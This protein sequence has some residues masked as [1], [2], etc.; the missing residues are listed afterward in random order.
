MTA[1]AKPL[2]VVFYHHSR[3]DI[4]DIQLRVINRMTQFFTGKVAAV[5]AVH[6][7]QQGFVV[8][9]NLFFLNTALRTY[10]LRYSGEPVF[11]PPFM[12]RFRHI[13][14]GRL[15]KCFKTQFI[16]VALA[17]IRIDISFTEPGSVPDIEPAL[18]TAVCERMAFVL[19]HNFVNIFLHLPFRFGEGIPGTRIEITLRVDMNVFRTALHLCLIAQKIAH[20][21]VGAEH[22]NMNER[23]FLHTV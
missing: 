16:Q 3:R 10:P 2:T 11:D 17:D 22:F 7:S 23:T 19:W 15:F 21:A 5:V 18:A 9:R 12:Q 13:G 14:C 8:I 20:P 1:A 4:P 6:F